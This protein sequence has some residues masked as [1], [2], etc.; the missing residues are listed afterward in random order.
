MT[1]ID[2]YKG[3]P[4]KTDIT[5]RQKLIQQIAKETGCRA[6]SV[7]RYCKGKLIPVK[8]VQDKIAEV[9]GMPVTELFPNEAN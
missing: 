7:Q 3:L 1:L 6:S 4:T 2:Y 5:P 8:A 9:L